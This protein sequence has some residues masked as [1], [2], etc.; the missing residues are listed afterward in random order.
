M[1]DASVLKGVLEVVGPH[2]N[3]PEG[4]EYD[5]LRLKEPGGAVRMVKKLG[6]VTTS[7]HISS[8]VWKVSSTS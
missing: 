3:L 4:S 2:R 6:L 5:Y 1:S 7:R 8:R